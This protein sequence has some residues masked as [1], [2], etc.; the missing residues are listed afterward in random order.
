MINKFDLM[1]FNN[2][3]N[4]V[5][6]LV[7]KYDRIAELSGENFNVF[8][9]LKLESSEVRLHSAFI[10]ELLNPKGSHGQGDVFLQLFVDRFNYKSIDFQANHAKVEIEKSIGFTNLGK[11]EGGRIDIV[12]TDSRG[13]QFLIENKIYAA[14][15]QNQLMRYHLYNPQAN[16]IYL[17]L[18]GGEVSKRA[19]GDLASDT[20]NVISYEKDI[21]QWLTACKKE[22]VDHPILR[23]GISQYINL[24]KHLTGQLINQLMNNELGEL[25]S[26]SHERLNAAFTISNTL[27]EATKL[28]TGRLE[29]IIEEIAK[30][31]DIQYSFNLNFDKKYTGFY[32]WRNG[33]E[34]VYLGF[35]FE[36]YDKGLDY[37]IVREREL[38]GEPDEITLDIISRL[39]VLNGKTT[40]W[41]PFFKEMEDPLHNWVMKNKEPWLAIIDG[42]IKPIIKSKVVEIMD[43]LPLELK[44]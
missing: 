20:Y 5:D 39:Q 16:L 1:P 6:A 11:S 41:W 25:I 9:I 31:L 26:S 23:E 24:I 27:S 29:V 3:L 32:F 13:K 14:D 4:S 36:N 10:A 40:S 28:L 17:C 8:K 43:L 42:S 30:E 15:Q 35:Q 18:F 19:K 33:W 7:R 38:L 21:I 44:L 22:A 34:H 2:I 12:I 37:G